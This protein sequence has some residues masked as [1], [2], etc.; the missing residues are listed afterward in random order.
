MSSL[1]RKLKLGKNKSVAIVVHPECLVC[2]A[3]DTNGTPLRRQID[4]HMIDHSLSETYKMVKDLGLEI[5]Q[6]LLKKH[7]EIHSPYIQDFRDKLKEATERAIAKGVDD[8]GEISWDPE[9]VLQTVIN[10]GGQKLVRGEINVDGKLLLGAL[11]EQGR[12]K[13]IGSMG[14]LLKNLDSKM[15]EKK[16]GELIESPADEETLKPS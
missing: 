11:A 10:I 15:F 8:I 7:A 2:G 9:E 1:T 6:A 3:R 13:Q 5:S 12:R 4:K 16:E 14:E